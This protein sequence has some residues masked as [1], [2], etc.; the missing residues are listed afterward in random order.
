MPTLSTVLL[1]I[2]GEVR[3]ANLQL[4]SNGDLVMDTIQ[5]YFK[6]K[7]EPECV[8]CYEYDNK[9]IF[10]FGYKKGKKGTENKIELPDP[11]VETTLFGDALI[12]ASLSNKW[13]NPVPF[14]VEQWNTF[15]NGVG[16]AGDEGDEDEDEDEEDLNRPQASF[17]SNAS[18]SFRPCV[19]R[20]SMN[21]PSVASLVYRLLCVGS[22]VGFQGSKGLLCLSAC[23]EYPVPYSIVA[24]PSMLSSSS[25]SSLSLLYPGPKSLRLFDCEWGRGSGSSLTSF[26]CA[27]SLG[28]I[29]P[30]SRKYLR[31]SLG[32]IRGYILCSC[33]CSP[34]VGVTT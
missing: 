4:N 30:H 1:S 32:S 16:D 25:S 27:Y 12:I 5:K 8:C 9:F 29:S 18:L 15:Y 24:I 19:S 33:S 13:D 23:T 22:G 21:S 7:D 14:T 28:V 6:K 17:S 11:Y 2:K 26:H 10:I 34:T 3:K 31:G 20:F